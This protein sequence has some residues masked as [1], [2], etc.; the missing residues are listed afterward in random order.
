MI[1]ED[2]DLGPIRPEHVTDGWRLEDSG[3]GWGLFQVV[4]GWQT[5]LYPSHD[6]GHLFL[7]CLRCHRSCASGGIVA[8][9]WEVENKCHSMDSGI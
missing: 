2:A 3:R 5:C 7:D 6:R 8:R 1:P 9:C 4:P